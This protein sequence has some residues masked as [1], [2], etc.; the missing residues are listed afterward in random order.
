LKLIIDLGKFNQI[1]AKLSEIWAKAIRF[2][3]NQNLA[4]PK[5]SD[6]LGYTFSE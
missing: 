5:T 2:R 4:S 6:L 1:W 3:Q